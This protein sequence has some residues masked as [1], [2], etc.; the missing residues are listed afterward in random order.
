L[1]DP[2]DI[3]CLHASAHFLDCRLNLAAVR[4]LE[5]NRKQP[6]GPEQEAD[7]P[8][9]QGK[10]PFSVFPEQNTTLLS[11]PLNG[12]FSA[13]FQPVLLPKNEQ[14]DGR[15]AEHHGENS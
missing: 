3:P 5:E 14:Y 10:L 1:E 13:F 12:H 2:L 6:N 11:R 9:A 8:C 7:C 15:G 4:L